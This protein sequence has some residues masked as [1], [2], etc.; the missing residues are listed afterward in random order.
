MSVLVLLLAHGLIKLPIHL[1]KLADNQ[2]NL[3]NT[4][5]KTDRVRKEYRR[6]LVEYH[7]QINICRSLEEKHADGYNRKY[8]DIL[9]EEIPEHDLEGQKIARSRNVGDFELKKG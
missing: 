1:W 2:Y 3:I 8:F 4:L 9:M 6:A 7:E 5:S